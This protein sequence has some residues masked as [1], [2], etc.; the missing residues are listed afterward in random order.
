MPLMKFKIVHMFLPLMKKALMGG[1]GGRRQTSV[2]L[3]IIRYSA[4]PACVLCPRGRIFL[5]S[6]T[7]FCAPQARF[8]PWRKYFCPPPPKKKKLNL[9]LMKKSLTHLWSM[10]LVAHWITKKTIRKDKSKLRLFLFL[11]L[12]LI[13]R[14][15]FKDIIR[16]T[17][18][19]VQSVQLIYLSFDRRGRPGAIRV[20]IEKAINKA[21]VMVYTV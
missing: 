6:R 11:I 17:K 10:C 7:F 21:R 19:C 15:K 16:I 8:F 20:K 9:L 3:A 2:S 18:K 4:P 5:G 12:L 1:I 13:L 14:R